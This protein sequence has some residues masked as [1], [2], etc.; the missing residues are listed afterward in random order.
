MFPIRSFWGLESMAVTPMWKVRLAIFQGV[1]GAWLRNIFSSPKTRA[2]RYRQA[3]AEE[4]FETWMS[5][6]DDFAKAIAAQIDDAGR[7]QEHDT[8]RFWQDVFASA[9]DFD[10][11]PENRS[12]REAMTVQA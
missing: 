10:A 7:R 5:C 6:G 12:K 11:D 2:E 3:V 4:A 1:A 8:V 9:H